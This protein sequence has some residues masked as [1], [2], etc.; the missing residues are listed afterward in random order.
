MECTGA[1]TCIL[2]SYLPEKETANFFAVKRDKVLMNI[3]MNVCMSI[4]NNE[5]LV[6]WYEGDDT[7]RNIGLQLLNKQLNFNVI[8]LLTKFIKEQ[9][10]NKIQ[11]VNF[12]DEIDLQL[13][14][15]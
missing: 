6:D 7:I 8:K 5:P 3:I 9:C 12:V 4:L 15:V 10:K 11:R 2:V 1:H 14:R 13:A